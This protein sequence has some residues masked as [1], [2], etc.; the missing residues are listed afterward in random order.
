M[1]YLICN[2]KENKT[3]NEI[4][5][6]EHEI[7]KLPKTDTKIIVC[8]SHPYYICFRNNN[9]YLGSQDISKYN[10]GSYTGEVSGKQLASL[11]V[12]YSLIGHCERRAYFE[13]NETTLIS[14]IVN[15]LKSGIEPIYIIGETKEE[16]ARG[17]TINVLERQ[18]GRVLNNFSREEL[19]NFLIVYEPVWAVD[20]NEDINKKEIK[21]TISFIK[22]I[23]R[24]Y[25]EL[26]LPVIYGGSVNSKNISLLMNIEEI[27]GVLLGKSS[28]DISI[29]KEV[30]ENITNVDK[31]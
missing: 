24:D 1:K 16:H 18:I 20:N 9:Y 4:I 12:N 23:I 31:F 6:Y 10:G 28:L 25:Y 5:T 30:Y 26:E 7:R 11:G 19:K 3:L 14:K 8:P 15:A 29:V 21:E 17:K 13:E 2:L 22:K 27:D